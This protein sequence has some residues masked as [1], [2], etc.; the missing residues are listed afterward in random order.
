MCSV[1]KLFWKT[2]LNSQEITATTGPL[3]HKNAC[4]FIKKRLLHKRFRVFTIFKELFYRI[5]FKTSQEKNTGKFIS[6]AAVHEK[7]S[8]TR[9]L[10]ILFYDY[11]HFH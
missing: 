2:S 10:Q 8:S 5:T 3:V 7:Q 9:I 4:T 6:E 11:H 1:K